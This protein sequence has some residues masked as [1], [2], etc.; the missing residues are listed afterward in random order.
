MAAWKREWRSLT[1][2]SWSPAKINVPGL[3]TAAGLLAAWEAAVRAGELD[4]AYLPAPSAIAVAAGGL[5]REGELWPKVV[6]TVGVTLL[7]WGIASMV[8]IGLGLL[9]GLSDRA[10]RWSMTSIEVLK[11][12]PPITLVPLA[13]LVFG[14]SIR[15]ELTLIVFAAAWPVLINSIGGVRAVPPE[16]TNVARML[17]LSRA[18]T[19]IKVVL[20]AAMPSAMVGLRLGLSLSLVLA[21]VAE[22]L[23]N[24]RG[25]GNG[26]IRA[27]QALQPE[28][29]FAYVLTVGLVGLAL[30]AS[31]RTA[32]SKVLRGRGYGEQ[33]G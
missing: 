11:G 22:M 17:R 6:H 5:I 20:P 1:K 25:L 27:Q 4:Y 12:I 3:L 28:T 10:R 32:S 21:V 2:Q 8:G 14:F 29:M 15:M 33:T 16:L 9:L 7:G 13:L 31:F 18:K 24:P 30:N 19:A 26:L 23:G